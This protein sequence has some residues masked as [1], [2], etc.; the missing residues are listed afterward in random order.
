VFLIRSLHRGGAERQLVEL[1]RCLDRERFRSTV[2]CFYPGGALGKDLLRDG[3]GVISLEKRGRWDIV[4]FLWRLIRFL[5]TLNPDIIYGYLWEPNLVTIALKP[6]FPSTKMVWGIR[7]SNVDLRKY[8]RVVRVSYWLARKLSRFADRIIAN[9]YA[10]RDHAVAHG[11]PADKITVVSNGIDT[12]VFVPDSAERKRIRAE[13]GI[14]EDEKI[15]GIAGR[16]DPVK[17]YETFLRAA[18]LL[19]GEH[20][21]VRFVCVGDGSETYK[22][23]LHGLAESLG[24]AGK[25]IWTGSRADMPA[26][27]NAFDMLCSASH[28]EGFSNV[29]GEAMSC[30]VPCVVTD[31]GDASLIVG[32]TGGVVRPESPEALRDGIEIMLGRLR[33][34]GADVRIEARQRIISE[35]SLE[36]L[37]V[38]TT[39]VLETL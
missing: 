25:V 15:V 38:R 33:A 16:L 18:T 13:W 17:G 5:R 28:S 31:V 37:V 34:E 7:A 30:G 9:S 23:E 2:L 29:I 24:L 20:R 19:M 6:L 22:R 27:Y 11:F 14:S 26:V 39:H 4:G 32:E 21:D 10:G 8:D 35:F 12:A 1:A 3:I 36:K